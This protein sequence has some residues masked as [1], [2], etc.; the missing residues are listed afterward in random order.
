LGNRRVGVL[1]IDTTERVLAQQL[2]Q[3]RTT[4]L[5]ALA[6][7][8]VFAEERERARIAEI[9]HD[10]LQ[11]VLVAANYTLCGVSSALPAEPARA[12]R[13]VADMLMEALDTSRFVTR[14]LRPPALYEHGVEAALA[15]LSR[16]LKEKHGL[17]VSVEVN[18]A[19]EPGS[20]EL[21]AFIFQAIR[22]LLLNVIKH[23]CV[24]EAQV[25]LVVHEEGWVQVA[26]RDSGVGFD[27]L[28]NKLSGMGLFAMRERV[29]YFGGRMEIRSAPGD[30]TCIRLVLP[31]G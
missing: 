13:K 24:K 5:R 6:A 14:S 26:V 22:E 28:K 2:L 7:E 30:G 31:K 10:D 11:Q 8:L 1:S 16:E 27:P 18:P 21:R 17:A 12:I 4:Q 19:A 20:S 9:L 23:A 3:E 25:R 29:G 15:D